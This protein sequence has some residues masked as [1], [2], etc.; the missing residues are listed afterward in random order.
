MKS[1][2]KSVILQKKGT[3]IYCNYNIYCYLFILMDYNNE[4]FFNSIIYNSAWKSYFL[5][6]DLGQLL[7]QI[8]YTWKFKSQRTKFQGRSV[9]HTKTSNFYQTYKNLKLKIQSDRNRYF[10]LK[11]RQQK[12]CKCL[13]LSSS[14][15]KRNAGTNNIRKIQ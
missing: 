12:F 13:F 15:R 6:L 3:N 1:H 10:F 9:L 2:G 14:F 11:T 7:T 4:Q 8:L 5:L